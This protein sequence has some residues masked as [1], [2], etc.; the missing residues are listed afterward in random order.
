M[1]EENGFCGGGA[2]WLG[3][4]CAS[5]CNQLLWPR[6]GRMHAR[7]AWRGRARAA[8]TD[9]VAG[10]ARS[11]TVGRGRADLVTWG[12]AGA[13]VAPQRVVG[14][15]TT[16]CTG[17]TTSL[18]A[19]DGRGKQGM[20]WARCGCAAQ[21]CEGCWVHL[22]NRPVSSAGAAAAT[23]V[24]LGCRCACGDVRLR[25]WPRAAA[26]NRGG[27]RPRAVLHAPS[28]AWCLVGC[29]GWYRVRWHWFLGGYGPILSV[30]AVRCG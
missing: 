12:A 20:V 8:N 1:G 13:S 14:E 28:L 27:S 2:V 30:V 6:R 21:A 22:A 29:C 10:G 5:T 17:G 4:S 7:R 11:A 16:S 9:L 15:G 23:D 26:G 25:V 18:R 24:V 19:C 3:A